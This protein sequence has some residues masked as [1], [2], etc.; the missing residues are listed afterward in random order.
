[1]R[2]FAVHHRHQSLHCQPL[3]P[4]FRL[5]KPL[6]SGQMLRE[7]YEFSGVDFRR[8][9]VVSFGVLRPCLELMSGRAAVG[10]LLVSI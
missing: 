4:Q 3:Q 6:P 7:A 9:S 10:Y 5:V 1:M 8:T 2:F